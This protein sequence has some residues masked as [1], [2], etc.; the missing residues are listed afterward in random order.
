[1]KVFR[2]CF[3]L[4]V[5]YL[6]FAAEQTGLNLQQTVCSL[7]NSSSLIKNHKE[8]SQTIMALVLL[9]EKLDEL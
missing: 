1:M 6:D 2:P 5:R 4:S 9:G 8:I 3:A 7:F